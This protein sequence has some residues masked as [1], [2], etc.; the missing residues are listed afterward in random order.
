VS[1]R[2]TA[3]STPAVPPGRDSAAA[4]APAYTRPLGLEH[5]HTCSTCRAASTPE[6][7]ALPV[8]DAAALD[9]PAGGSRDR[10]A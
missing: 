3:A 10:A 1:R 9:P 8:S 4:W 7:R 2:R 5:L 6:V